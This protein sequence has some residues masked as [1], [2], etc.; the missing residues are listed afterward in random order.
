MSAPGIRTGEPQAA[1]AE[2]AHL[3]TAPPGWP[4]DSFSFKRKGLQS[5]NHH[6]R[7]TVL[8]MVRKTYTLFPLISCIQIFISA[9]MLV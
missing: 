8:E 7:F 4:Q 2:R 3:T 9:K 1:E 5:E 6:G